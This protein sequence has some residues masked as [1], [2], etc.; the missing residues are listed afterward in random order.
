VAAD[1]TLDRSS[2]IAWVSHAG[3]GRYRVETT[4]DISN[5]A[6][7]GSVGDTGVETGNGGF[8]RTGRW[9]TTDNQAIAVETFFKEAAQT[10][11]PFHLQVT[12]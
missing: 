2:G 10:D 6:Y 11:Y 4:M 5:C 3:T 9:D 7:V 1:G 8:T 12:C